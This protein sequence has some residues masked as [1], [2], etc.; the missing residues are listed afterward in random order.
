M[1]MLE[2][3]LHGYGRDRSSWASCEW[4]SFINR[5]NVALSKDFFFKKRKKKE[6]KNFDFTCLSEIL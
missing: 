4:F 1:G 5:V 2:T 6:K 3:K